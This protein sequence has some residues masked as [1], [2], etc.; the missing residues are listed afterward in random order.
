MSGVNLKPFYLGPYVT[1]ADV[2]KQLFLNIIMAI[3]FG[4]GINFLTKVKSKDF[5]WI[6]LLFGLGIEATQL[7]ISLTLGWAYRIIDINDV[8]LNAAGVLIGFGFFKAFSQWYLIIIDRLKIEHT[9]PVE[10][11]YKLA[12]R[13]NLDKKL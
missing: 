7:M 10:Y 4:F 6:P 3:P 2:R 13:R 11:V 1:F 8:L 9:E 5:L 12:D